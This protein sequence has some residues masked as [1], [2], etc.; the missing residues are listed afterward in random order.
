[1]WERLP[2]IRLARARRRPGAGPA[3][4]RRRRAACSSR[5]RRA[6]LP[7]DQRAAH[8]EQRSR[9]L[10]ERGQRRH[11]AGQSRRRSAPAP[12]PAAQSSARAFDDASRC[13]RQ[14]R[15]AAA[16]MK[17]HLR[18]TDSTRSTRSPGPGDRDRQAR[19]PGSAADVRDPRGPRAIQPRGSA[20]RL[21]ATC[22]STASAGPAPTWRRAG[23]PARASA[24]RP[25][26][27]WH[28]GPSDHWAAELFQA[29]GQ[30]R[31]GP[32]CA[33]HVLRGAASAAA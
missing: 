15:A 23:R 4:R 31:L 1:M 2:G 9:V 18:R 6:P 5:R 10:D 8:H 16:S 27:A 21:S 17:S 33:F 20:A 13:R 30:V 24:A 25:A 11:R 3:A 22:T 19:E 29:P 7:G 12:L 26:C 32:G 28:P 14:P